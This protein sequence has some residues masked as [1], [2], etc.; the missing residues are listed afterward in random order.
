MSGVVV[1]DMTRDD[2]AFVGACARATS[3][4]EQDGCAQRRVSWLRQSFAQGVR[5]KVALLDEQPVGFAYVLPIEHSPWGPRGR[6]LL[7]IPCLYVQPGA[8]HQ[9]V[10]LALVEAADE[11]VDR[12]GRKGICVMVNNHE[13]WFMPQTY[14]EARGFEVATERGLERIL[15]RR[16]TDDAERPEVLEPAYGFRPVRDKVV[17]DL[18]WNRFCLTSELEAQRVREVALE[19]GD[20]VVLNEHQ[21]CEA[22]ELACHQI[23]RAIYVQGARM[24]W[25]YEAPREGI[26]TALQEALAI[27]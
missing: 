9:G 25:G 27:L 3:T 10:G 1:R 23:P 17:V 6:D 4:T 12:Q 26:R 11:E 20:R 19:L 5:A 18:F 24:D 14:F 15:W 16:H 2:E 22:D 8:E 21:T 7:V 13:A